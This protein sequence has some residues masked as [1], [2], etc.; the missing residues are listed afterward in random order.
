MPR[1]AWPLGAA[2]IIFDIL[3]IFIT[4]LWVPY[5]GP[6]TTLAPALRLEGRTTTIGFR[7]RYSLVAP[8]TNPAAATEAR[9]D[10]RPGIQITN[11]FLY[12]F[13]IHQRGLSG[14]GLCLASLIIMLGLFV[15]V[16]YLFPRRLLRMCDVISSNWR[17]VLRSVAIGILGYIL[18]ALLIVLLA[19][20]VIGIPLA[21]LAVFATLL[22]SLVGLVVSSLT[23]GR[24]VAT[25]LGTGLPSPVMELTF[26]ILLIFP[27]SILPV[28]GWAV[29]TLAAALGFGAALLTKFGSEEGWTLQV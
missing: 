7:S 14:I 28:V 11:Y 22:L 8:F 9:P 19:I 17:Q 18:V 6:E 16:L 2:L 27:L 21:V 12:P 24:W 3:V 20:Q 13:G 25:Q 10:R 1:P 23:I 29:A 26:G 15:A 4:A 5:D